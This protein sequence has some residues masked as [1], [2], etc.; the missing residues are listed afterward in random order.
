M[1]GGL[2]GRGHVRRARTEDRRIEVDRHPRRSGVRLEFP[3][4]GIGRDLWMFGRAGEVRPRL[5]GGLD[6]GDESGSLRS[7]LMHWKNAAAWYNS[8]RPAS[9]VL[10]LCDAAMDIGTLHSRIQYR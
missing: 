2:G 7:R 3:T 1:E 5:R 6:Q 8:A 4:A 10:T 9:R